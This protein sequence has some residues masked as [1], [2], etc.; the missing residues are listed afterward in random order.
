MHAERT[1]KC[2]R[3]VIFYIDDRYRLQ[4]HGGDRKTFEVQ[5]SIKPLVL[6]SYLLAVTLYQW[7]H[8]RNRML[9]YRIKCEIWLPYAGTGGMLLPLNGRFTKGK[10]KLLSCRKV[11]FLTAPHCQFRGVGQGMKQI[12]YLHLYYPLCHAQWDKPR[13]FNVP[14]SLSRQSQVNVI[15]MGLPIK[16]WPP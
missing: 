16:S 2:L 9:E 5:T 7:N 15:L 13:I 6:V 8:D 1:G 4:S 14:S 10:L 12:Y 3:P 11:S